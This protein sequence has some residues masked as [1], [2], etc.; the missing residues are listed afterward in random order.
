MASINNIDLRDLKRFK[1]TLKQMVVNNTSEK[2][3]A[4]LGY[5]SIVAYDVLNKHYGATDFTVENPIFEDGK[6]VIYVKGENIAFDEFG[7]GFYAKGSYKGELPTQTL[8][9][10]SAGVTQTTNG[11]DYYYTWQG[12]PKKKP[13][14]EYDGV[15]GWFTKKEGSPYFHTGKKASNRFY[16]AV[17]EIKGKFKVNNK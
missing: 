13:K 14:R 11:W 1:A 2:K 9:F 8:V 3:N 6:S 4:K 5:A 7:T 10:E 17:V 15:K 16:N 12:D